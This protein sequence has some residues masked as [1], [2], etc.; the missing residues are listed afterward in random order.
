MAAILALTKVLLPMTILFSLHEALKRRAFLLHHLLLRPEP[1]P[2]RHPFS[3]QGAAEALLLS[4]LEGHHR[5]LLTESC[6]LEGK[7]IMIRIAILPLSMVCPHRECH[8]CLLAAQSHPRWLL[9]RLL[10]MIP[11]TCT[12]RLPPFKAPRGDQ[13]L[14]LWKRDLLLRLRLPLCRLVRH[15]RQRHEV[16]VHL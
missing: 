16:I 2:R 14:R 10:N 5:R 7:N 3:R 6:H 8:P 4:L 1:F 9:R 11:R 13:Q 12:T 15:L